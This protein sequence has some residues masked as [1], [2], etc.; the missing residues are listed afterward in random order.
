MALDSKDPIPTGISAADAY[1]KLRTWYQ[2]HVGT[3]EARQDDY[4]KKSAAY[5]RA[6]KAAPSATEMQDAFKQVLTGLLEWAYHESD[7]RYKMAAYATAGS[8]YP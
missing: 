7:G 5:I 8:K 2:A 3:V 4:G 6:M 1:A